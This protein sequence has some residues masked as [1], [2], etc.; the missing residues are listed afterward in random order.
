MANHWSHHVPVEVRCPVCE[1]GPKTSDHALFLCSRA[2]KVWE[3]V[4]P[5]VVQTEE[6][7]MDIK[8]QWIRLSTCNTIDLNLICVGA[9]VIWN[10]RNNVIHNRPI[11]TI[12]VRCDWVFAYLDEFSKAQVDRGPSLPHHFE[13]HS[14]ISRGEEVIMNTD[15]A[16]DVINRKIGMGMVIRDKQG[17]L[18]E[19]SSRSSHICITL[20]CAEAVAVLEGLRFARGL[21]MT[22]VTILSDSLSLVSDIQD[23][24]QGESCITTVLWDIRRIRESFDWVF[25]F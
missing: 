4:C 16:Y 20:L 12:D 3:G 10:D 6:D 22:C 21:G 7:C 24:H 18:K 1:E 8:D 17:N 15:V 5:D 19:V 25:F 23:D 2:R 13:F 9:W 14:L 11:P